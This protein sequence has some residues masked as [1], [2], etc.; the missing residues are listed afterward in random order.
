MG[1]LE[2][3]RPPNSTGLTQCRG[4]HEL[5]SEPE[6]SEGGVHLC[7]HTVDNCQQ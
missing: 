3:M 1:W 6:I 4:G 5:L 7:C 2:P